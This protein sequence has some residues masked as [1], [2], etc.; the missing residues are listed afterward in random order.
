MT[1]TT[2]QPVPP[3]PADKSI[4]LFEVGVEFVSQW[5]LLLLASF[6]LFL[7]C[8]AAIYS[9]T[10]LFEADATILPQG[11]ND[12][13]TLSAFFSTRSPGDI[14]LGLLS[15]R[16]VQDDVI[17]RADLMALYKT[18]SRERARAALAGSSTF[19]IGKGSLVSIVVRTDKA[20][21]AQRIANAYLEALQAQRV[22]M[23]SREAELHDRFFEQQLNK[24]AD[25][26]AAAE[27]ALKNTEEIS[28][29][30]QP[31]A[32]TTI[33]LNAIAGVR[34]Q[35]TNLQVQ[36]A[37]ARLGETDQNAN[38]KVLE[39]QIA[40]LQAQERS[41]ESAA[42]GTAAGAAA[43]AKKMPGLN[44]EY[45]RKAREVRYHEAL[46]T[47]ISN[48]YQTARLTEGYS[49][50]SFVVIDRAVAPETKA[51]PLRRILLM[52]SLVASIFL[53][54]VIVGL[55]LLWTSLM[56]DPAHV[57]ELKTLRASFRRS[58]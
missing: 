50:A 25:A 55:K 24:E 3:D 36:L 41:M 42:S 56:T 53:G 31:E 43:S 34:A 18:K 12:P 49:G 44:L 8:V 32:Q 11:G 28:G 14:F 58:R 22:N 15:S 46:F 23:L 19:G 27:Q 9:I 1:D 16:G 21:V 35:I 13:S 4:D 10:P 45:A 52:L 17:D 2:L 39:S 40:Q 38:V 7:L 30:V 37:S 29:V 57:Q 48:Q 5:R 26:L 54:C 51:W 47:S 33:G 6:V 20:E